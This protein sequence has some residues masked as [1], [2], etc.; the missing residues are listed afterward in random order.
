VR[1]S[2]SIVLS[3]GALML[4]GCREN[5]LM[6]RSL[7]FATNT[8][9]GLD[10]GVSPEAGDPGHITIGYKRSEGVLNPVF[11]NHDAADGTATSSDSRKTDDYYLDEAYSVI[12]KFQGDAKGTQGSAEGRVVL[13]QWFATGKAA[14]ELA[15]HGGAAALVD[16]RN[17]AGLLEKLSADGETESQARVRYDFLVTVYEALRNWEQAD[18]NSARKHVD[19]LDRLANSMRLAVGTGPAPLYT[20]ESPDKK[21]VAAEGVKWGS[22]HPFR[23]LMSGMGRW[24]Q[25]VAATESAI[26]NL[27]RDDDVARIKIEDASNAPNPRFA[28]MSDDQKAGRVRDDH[29]RQGHALEELNRQ[30]YGDDRLEAAVTYYLRV[31]GIKGES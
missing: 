18:D 22:H 6:D 27:G 1:I 21:L 5:S 8:T 29:R 17:A 7:V 30:L 13:S 28:Q 23:N 10:V 12:A 26:A 24:R 15:K 20:W 2:L 19:D 3:V 14:D 16:G 11:F 4:L 9:F 25:S 31:M